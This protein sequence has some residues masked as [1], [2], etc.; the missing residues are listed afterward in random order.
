MGIFLKAAYEVLAK[1]KRP[2]GAPEIT[3]IAIREGSLKSSGKTPSQTMKAR[4]STEILRR[5]SDSVF[6]RVEKG[7]F[8]LREWKEAWHEHVAQRF[9][10]ALFDEEIVVF[11]AASL[12]KYVPHSG[13][14]PGGLTSWLVTVGPWISGIRNP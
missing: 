10:K 5:G 11:P 12:T 14:H 3:R 8:A 7:K 13:L 9:Q 2:L 1:E 4:L 6:M